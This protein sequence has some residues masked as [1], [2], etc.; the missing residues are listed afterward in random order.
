MNFTATDGALKTRVLKIAGFL[1]FKPSKLRIFSAVVFAAAVCAG[2]VATVCAQRQGTAA[3]PAAAA[4]APQ[5]APR[6]PAPARK[7]VKTRK[8]PA[9]R[10]TGRIEPQK[11]NNLLYGTIERLETLSSI[12]ENLGLRVSTATL[13]KAYAVDKAVGGAAAGYFKT[14]A[15]APDR[16]GMKNYRGLLTS[17]LRSIRILKELR[18]RLKPAATEPALLAVQ[19]LYLAMDA[20]LSGPNLVPAPDPAGAR[21][22][23]TGAASESSSGEAR[24]AGG[25]LANETETLVTI[26]E[27]SFALSAY[28]KEEGIYPK[29]LKDLAPK[30]IP[31][32]PAIEIAGHAATTETTDIDSAD[33][34]ADLSKAVKDTG[35]W[36]YFSNKKSKYYGRVLV[37]CSHK[38]AQGT[39][40]YKIGE[41]KW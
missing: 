2:T 16:E 22:G 36:I 28:R 6:S 34:D 21:G 12:Y 39:E 7:R 8:K 31:E 38:N 10:L 35:K 4:R 41:T 26:S 19:D 1:T 33:Y 13:R 5:T 20:E 24:S 14:P 27:V 30:Y 23:K 11:I 40:F 3:V 29:R 15:P 37:D 32:I 17:V 25:E 9:A 18:I